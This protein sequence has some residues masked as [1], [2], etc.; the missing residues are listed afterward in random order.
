[1]KN[2]EVNEKL[3]PSEVLRKRVAEECKVLY[4]GETA[5]WACGEGWDPILE[6]LSYQLE[7]L[8][9]R[10]GEK[11]GIKVVA[12]Q[13]KEKY[14]TLRFYFDCWIEP[15]EELTREQE[16]MRHYVRD[17]ADEYVRKAEKECYDV[18]EYCGD[19]IGDAKRPRCM[20]L[21]WIK[22]LCRKCVLKQYEGKERYEMDG[23]F[24]EGTKR[25]PNPFRKRRKTIKD[26][27]DK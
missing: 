18:C 5:F 22:Y 6:K 11:W 16:V 3:T 15:Y 10:Y 23:K 17:L 4:G 12:A 27:G 25:I 13:V 2:E 8:N 9:V 7:S 19:P 20:T 26:K 14:G 24:Y 21:G 1:M